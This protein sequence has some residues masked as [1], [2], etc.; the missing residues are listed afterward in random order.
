MY[1]KMVE[2]LI[3]KKKLMSRLNFETATSIKK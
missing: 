1:D 2:N 3:D